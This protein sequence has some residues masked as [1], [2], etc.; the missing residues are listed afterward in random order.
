MSKWKKLKEMFGAC[1]ESSRLLA[2][3]KPGQRDIIIVRRIHTA[4]PSA[5]SLL[6]LR[7][8]HHLR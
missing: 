5:L 3:T 1:Q 2:L 8:L 4:F 6:V 7:L